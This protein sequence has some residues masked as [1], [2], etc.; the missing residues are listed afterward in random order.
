MRPRQP[1]FIGAAMLAFLSVS[2]VG[3]GGGGPTDYGGE[4]PPPTGPGQPPPPSTSNA[5]AV[6]NNRFEPSAITVNAGT[7]VTWTW[8]TCTDDGY[9]GP[10]TCA[11]HNVTF[12]AGGGSATQSTGSYSRLFNSA[13]TFNYRCTLH[14]PMTGQV[15]VR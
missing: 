8:D 14:P 6:R 12:D 11:N 13:G 15:I 2:G 1:A 5:V 9:G 10:Q 3:C 7:T 4:N